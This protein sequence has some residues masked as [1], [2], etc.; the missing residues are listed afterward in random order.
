MIQDVAAVGYVQITA[1]VCICGVQAEK[2]CL[3]E[4]KKMI[5]GYA[6]GYVHSAIA[7]CVT[8]AEY[9]LSANGYLKATGSCVPACVPIFI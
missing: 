4:E 3:A 6:V 2:L 5:D 7:V 9:D 1:I 8:T